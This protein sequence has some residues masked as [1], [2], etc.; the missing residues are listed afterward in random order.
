MNYYAEVTVTERTTYR[1]HFKSDEPDMA[2]VTDHI[3]ELIRDNNV[4]DLAFDV[5]DVVTDV[6]AISDYPMHEGDEIELV[7]EV[8]EDGDYWT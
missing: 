3:T 2:G 6:Y 1:V 7:A 4:Q 5:P 8:P